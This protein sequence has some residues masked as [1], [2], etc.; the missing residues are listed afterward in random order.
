M[1]YSAMRFSNIQKIFRLH[2]LLLFHW[3]NLTISFQSYEISHD[4]HSS[5]F[6]CFEIKIKLFCHFKLSLV[7]IEG[8]FWKSYLFC[9]LLQSKVHSIFLRSIINP[10]PSIK[11]LPHLTY[12]SFLWFSHKGVFCCFYMGFS[13]IFFPKPKI[14]SIPFASIKLYK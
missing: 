2:K 7:V 13:L 8:L 11:V 12:R 3:F 6:V 1:N 14:E 5:M 10:L 9:S 4:P